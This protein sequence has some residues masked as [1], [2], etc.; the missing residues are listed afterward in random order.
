MPKTTR[1]LCARTRPVRLVTTAAAAAEPRTPSARKRRIFTGSPPTPVGATLFTASPASRS[2]QRR[3]NGW[4]TP[5]ARR[6]TRQPRASQSDTTV[7]GN[8]AS[9]RTGPSPTRRRPTSSA[10]PSWTSQASKRMPARAARMD[11]VP[12][13]PRGARGT[14]SGAGRS[15]GPSAALIAFLAPEKRAPRRPI[16]SCDGPRRHWTL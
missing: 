5:K 3:A 12:P 10:P 1:R 4:A 14:R 9:G 13:A 6:T 11:T 7:Y 16:P 15:V 8:N 2:S